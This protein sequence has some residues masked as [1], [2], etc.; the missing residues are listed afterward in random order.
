LRGATRPG[1]GPP[2]GLMRDWWRGRSIDDGVRA[3]AYIA[4]CS[5]YTESAT[6]SNIRMTLVVSGD[7][8]PATTVEHECMCRHDRW[9]SPG[10]TLPVTVDPHDPTR[11]RVEWDEV[12]KAEDVARRQAEAMAARLNA[13]AAASTSTG[14]PSADALVAQLQQA[15]PGA[16]VS[17]SHQSVDAT[18][19]PQLAAQILG[20]LQGAG[21]TPASDDDPTAQL[22]RLAALHAQGMLTDAEFAAAKAKVLGQ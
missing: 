2:M 13:G 20:A 17:V 21:V 8:I 4:A 19:D 15:F 12:P 16:Q 1:Y 10:E 3:S 18:A 6:S 7:G 9:P 22:E 5:R 14:D 11:L